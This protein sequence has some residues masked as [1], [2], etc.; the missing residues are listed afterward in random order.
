MAVGWRSGRRAC[1]DCVYF[2]RGKKRVRGIEKKKG[3]DGTKE[4]HNVLFPLC[5]T[6]DCEK[7]VSAVGLQH[8]RRRHR[9]LKICFFSS[10]VLWRDLHR[11]TDSPSSYSSAFTRT[12]NDLFFPGTLRA[13]SKPSSSSCTACVRACVQSLPRISALTSTREKQLRLRE[14]SE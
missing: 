9:P 11:K 12:L 6:Y 8:R 5:S 14:W 4:A 7:T 1:L 10:L 13:E 3:S 2:A